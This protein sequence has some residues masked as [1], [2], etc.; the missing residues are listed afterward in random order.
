MSQF[1]K[2]DMEYLF[3]RA[4]QKWGR[5]DRDVISLSVADID[6]PP[7]REI[8]ETVA[9][10]LP[11]DR[12]PYGHPQGEL[13]LRRALAEKV[14]GQNGLSASEEEIL[15]VPGTM[16]GIFLACHLCLQP[17]DEAILT[18]S[19]VYGPFWKNVTGMGAK[20]VSHDLA[21]ELGFGYLR[22]TLESLVTSR[23]KLLMVCNPHNPTGRV[24]DRG[25]L[26][27]IAQMAC[28]HDLMIFS[29]ELYEDL[30]F[31]G[32]YRSMAALGDEVFQRC[33]TVFGFSKAFGIPGY[34]VAYMVIPQSWKE[35]ALEV[36]E[37][38]IVHTDT[39]AQG[40][41]MGALKGADAWLQGF[42]AHLK[43]MR[44][45]SLARIQGISGL[46]CTP[47]QAT[48]FLF[49]DIRAIGL[50]SQDLADHLLQRGRVVV[51]PGTD[52]GPSGEGFIRLNLATSWDI[53]EEAF[54]RMGRALNEL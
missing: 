25:D 20:P 16:F 27:V 50:S 54:D 5:W 23:T 1:D 39:L 3:L 17:G 48:P 43:E 22:E 19:P 24:L 18:P 33:L 12:T 21:L 44:D 49:P 52:F 7:P 37:R 40:A 11:E 36:T 35:R 41:A 10:W 9:Q 2:T 51:Q 14:R 26:E 53:L 28:D 31:E 47:S 42:V 4:N 34:R 8:R 6:Y 30:V 38:I 29:D 15:V 46:I 32:E 13:E 45:R